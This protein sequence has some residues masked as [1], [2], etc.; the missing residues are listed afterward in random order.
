MS[1]IFKYRDRYASVIE[2]PRAPGE[3]RRQKWV[4]GKSR[5][6]VQEKLDTLR[7][8]IA[9][10]QYIDESKITVQAYLR[11][12]FEAHK[13][14]I[15][16]NTQEGYRINIEKHLI[17]RIGEMRLKNLTPMR[18]QKLY[19]ELLESGRA[20]KKGG[21]S[22]RSVLYVHRVLKKALSAAVRM[23]LIRENPA[24][25][26][27]PPKQ[28]KTAPS[29]DGI[30]TENQI[31]E[32]LQAF[33]G[34]RLEVAIHLS[35]CMGLRRGEIL[36]L[37]WENIDLENNLLHVRQAAVYSSATKKIHYK[38]PKSREGYRTLVIPKET[39]ELLKKH[40][41]QQEEDKEFFGRKY[42]DNNL[43][44]CKD[45]G[46]PYL[47]GSFSHT[48]ER[49]LKDKGLPKTTLHQLRHAYATL[50]M[51]YRTDVKIVSSLLGHSRT[52]FT[53]DIYQHTLKEMKQKAA[54][55]VS[56]KLLRKVNKNKK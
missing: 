28:E 54:K 10:N 8:L 41:E 5:E 50:L 56:S 53:Q 16:I 35:A 49:A 9:T 29:G 48:F 22:P 55:T 21:L 15:S 6:E 14:N 33:Q 12:W 36:G 52:E 31:V 46:E 19:A 17:P 51:K 47:P 39:A 45:N 3:K 34:D 26:V 43:V 23:K 25:S 18:I 42:K 4:Y 24:G 13:P 11:Q 32:L 38:E 30:Y 2:L 7:Y 1:R 40:R 27:T 20:D 44:V 37:T